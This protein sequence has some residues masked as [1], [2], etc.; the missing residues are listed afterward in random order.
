MRRDEVVVAYKY[1]QEIVGDYPEETE[2]RRMFEALE[3]RLWTSWRMALQ[4]A[5]D[6]A[7]AKA[8]KDLLDAA[9]FDRKS[10]GILVDAV[11][12]S[13]SDYRAVELLKSFA[14]HYPEDMQIWSMIGNWIEKMPPGAE[15]IETAFDVL[16][17][18][19]GHSRALAAL[20]RLVKDQSA[21]EA[22][23]RL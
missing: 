23:P 21:G 8:G 7:I 13:D 4:T 18:V 14:E 19:A 20:S 6:D 10:I 2:L 1:L 16:S 22:T 11:S 3:R 15:A 9:L 17:H 12:K 5:H